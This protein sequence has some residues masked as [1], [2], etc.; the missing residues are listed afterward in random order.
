MSLNVKVQRHWMRP[1]DR[2]NRRAD[3]S[4]ICIRWEKWLDI[5]APASCNPL[6]V[7]EELRVSGRDF[8]Q[9]L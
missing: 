6:I 8:D 3:G 2:S 9:H 5:L 4:S 7:L 1:C